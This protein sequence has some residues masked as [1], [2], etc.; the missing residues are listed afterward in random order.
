MDEIYYL[1]EWLER[2]AVNDKGAA[3][4]GSIPAS[5]NLRGSRKSGVE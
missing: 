5:S 3:V 2:L 4:P 1:A